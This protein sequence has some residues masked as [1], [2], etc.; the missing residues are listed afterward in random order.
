MHCQDINQTIR[1]LRSIVSGIVV[2]PCLIA[3]TAA[4]PTVPVWS[5]F[6]AAFAKEACA[7]YSK[8]A[9]KEQRIESLEAATVVAM[10]ADPEIL[11]LVMSDEISDQDSTE[12]SMAIMLALG[13]QC[14]QKMTDL[15]NNMGE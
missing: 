12:M 7:S 10:T 11:K 6:G 8:N 5:A 4:A 2:G 9:S 15:V 1:P 3:T 13:K 14:P